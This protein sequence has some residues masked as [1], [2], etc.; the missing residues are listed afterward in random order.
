MSTTT[1]P[2]DPSPAVTPLARAPGGRGPVHAVLTLFSSVTFGIVL[3]TILFIYSTIGSA[4][5]LYPVSANIF[6]RGVWRH[7]FVRTW[8]MFEMTEFEWFHTWFFNL[9]IAL[10]VANM[11]ITTL[12]RIPLTIL[13][14]GVWCIHAGIVTLAIG[15]VIYFGTKVEGDTPVIRREVVVAFEGMP[16]VTMP[17]IPGANATVRTERGEYRFEVAQVQ[18]DWPIMSEPDAGKKAYSVNMVVRTPERE[19]IRQLLAGYPQYTEDVIPGR[20]RTVK[21]P[22]FGKTIIDDSFV[23]TLEPKAQDRFWVMHSAALAVRDAGTREWTVRPV[24]GLP[25]YNEYVS[26]PGDVWA[27]GIEPRALN[28]VVPAVGESDPLSSASVRVTGFLRYADFRSVFTGGGGTPN[29]L[30]EIEVRS[31]QGAAAEAR[32][33]AL[34]AAQSSAFQGEVLFTAVER[35]EQ[36]DGVGRGEKNRLV[37]RAPG[38]G[39]VEVNFT[40]AEIRAA[41]EALEQAGPEAK[42]VFT[43]IP[44]TAFEFRVKESIDRLPLQDGSAVSLAV[45]EFRTPEGSFT[46]WVFE[47]VLRNR[48]MPISAET[49]A[50]DPHTTRDPDPRITTEYTGAPQPTI[51]LVTVKGTDRLA[52]FT[53]DDS[54]ERT[55]VELRAGE[56]AALRQG[57][58]LELKRFV[59]DARVETRPVIVP[60]NQRDKD[61]D[62]AHLGNMMQVEVTEAGESRRF[63]LPFHAYAVPSEAYAEM[64]SGRYAPTPIELPSGR[65]VELMFTREE[66]K[67]PS[68]VVLEDFVLAT[69]V[70]GYTGTVASVRDWTSVVRFKDGETL[71]EAST[72]S[73]N[74]PTSHRGMW[75]F[76]KTWDPNGLKFTGLGVGNREGVVTQLAGCTLAVFGMVYAFYVKPILR[77][78]RI[79]AVHARVAAERAAVRE[80][81]APAHELNGDAVGAGVG[82]AEAGRG[83]MTM[84]HER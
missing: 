47:D 50:A 3:L 37:V 48:D 80:S 76:Q 70:G 54:G 20:G 52:A 14:V 42:P 22:E 59:P 30:A 66:R 17:A 78:R 15:S 40:R 23:M 39:E 2:H 83:A 36:I 69:H 44:G 60:R 4:G 5:V 55:R 63:W 38:G 49:G 8:P 65:R 75:F 6:D 29:P 18:P 71:S 45:V 62:T 25:R 1:L 33:M 53:A 32:L 64:N 73:T 31:A 58:T 51:H 10:I 57:L 35:E 61:I 28:L 81:P 9:N 27:D 56:S 24:R 43:P 79:Q 72:I 7:E 74:N 77:R 68:P 19:F 67:L 34:D 16:P 13:S 41:K 84:E 11:I 12:R 46:R 21:L 26:S 82:S